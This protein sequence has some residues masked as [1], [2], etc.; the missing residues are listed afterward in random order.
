MIKYLLKG[1]TCA[2]MMNVF[3]KNKL[4]LPIVV[5]MGFFTGLILFLIDR[6]FP[7]GF[8][9]NFDIEKDSEALEE[10]LDDSKEED[11]EADNL[12]AFFR[13]NSSLEQFSD[14][15]AAERGLVY[16]NV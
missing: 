3:S 1:F 13:Y 9:E 5:K 11:Q 2:I 8:K 6:M 4:E 16:G 14:K 12:E 15:T 10:L 7:E